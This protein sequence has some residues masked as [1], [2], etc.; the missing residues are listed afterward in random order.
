M[1]VFSK[2]I[3]IGAFALALAVTGCA[4]S[5]HFHSKTGRAYVSVAAQAV[6]CDET[7]ARTVAAAGAE[8]IGTISAKALAVTANDEDVA[9]KAAVVAAKNGGTHIV[10]TDKGVEYFTVM[11][12]GQT[13][14]Q[15]VRNGGE[16]QCEST[17]TEATAS[18]Y[19]KPTAKFVVLRLAPEAWSRLPESLRPIAR[20]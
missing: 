19:A 10:L 4:T 7:E 14:T 13:S 12:P 3:A 1:H 2:S 5:A 11:T 17:S 16:L 20:M 15:C 6:R 8:V 9:D 18:T